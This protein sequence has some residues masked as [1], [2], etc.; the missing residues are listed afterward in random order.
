[1]EEK[2][3]IW[4]CS[5]EDSEYPE[6]LKYYENM[7]EKLYVR[8]RL[9]KKDKKSVAIVG[10]RACSRYGA[11]QAYRFAKEL[12]GC[13]VQIISGLAKG[14]DGNAHQGALDGGGDTFAVMG[15]GADLCY[16]GENQNLYECIAKGRG[17]ILSEFENGTPPYARNFPRRNRIISG[18]A[19]LVLVVEAKKRSG[20]LITAGLALDQGKA[21]FAIPGRV[22]D[23]LSEGCNRLIADGAGLADSV[24]TILEELKISVPCRKDFRPISKIRLASQEEMVYSCLD[25]QPKNIEEIVQEI[26]LQTGKTAEILLK[27]QL[28][29]LVEEPV[30]NYYARAGG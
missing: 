8:G 2:G 30:K 21:V 1:M 18:M 9:P 3:T 23:A 19:D 22:G 17:G 6:Q 14:V 13:G 16:P 7:P 27:L 20:S 12:A 28:D 25:L 26:H 11:V 4:C 24:E 15:C 10:A 5:R 29:G